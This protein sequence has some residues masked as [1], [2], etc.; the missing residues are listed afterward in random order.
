ML[1]HRKG[2]LLDGIG[3]EL[4]RSSAGG[5]RKTLS[6][7]LGAAGDMTVTATGGSTARTLAARFGERFN[8]RDFGAAGDGTTDDTTAF[9]AAITAALASSSIKTV[10][11]PDGRYSLPGAT[12]LDPG[13]GGIAIVG[14]SREGTI[15]LIN[16][17]TSGAKR[18][19]FKNIADTAKGDLSFEN[20]QFQ[21]TLAT[22]A[23][24]AGNPLWLDYYSHVRIHNCKFYSI[25]GEAMDFHYCGA[26]ECTDSWFENIA[27]DGVRVR[28]TSDCI[29]TDNTFYRLGDDPIAIHT[30]ASTL[31]SFTPQ[32][33]RI[34]VTNNIATNV[35][36]SIK[37]IGAKKLLC[38]LNVV[39][40]A[41][42][43]GIIVNYS[44][45]EGKN[46]TY[47]ILIADNIVSDMREVTS[48]TPGVATA[49]ITIKAMQAVGAS[50]TH[51]AF[52]YRWD[53][54]DGAV[55]RPWD[56]NQA[57]GTDSADA[58]P[59]MAGLVIRG[60]ICR[61]TLPTAAAFSDW[62]YGSAL[63]QGVA[64]DPAMDDADQRVSN[65]V[66][67]STVP[68][69]VNVIVE[70]NII[71]HVASTFVFPAPVTELDYYNISI[72]NNTVFDARDYGVTVGSA[73]KHFNC[74]IEGNVFDLDYFRENSN[75]N[76]DGSYDASTVPRAIDLGNCEGVQIKNNTFRNCCQLV[77]SNVMTTLLIEGNVAYC[78]APAAAGFNT[79]NKG[80]GHILL[81]LKAWR[82]IIADSDPTSATYG[83]IASQ[84]LTSSASMPSAGWYY[85]G[86]FVWDSGPATNGGGR[87]GWARV[88]TGTGHV[89]DTDWVEIGGVKG[90][91][92]ATDN[93]VTRWDAVTGRLLQNSTV[94]LSDA[95]QFAGQIRERYV[96]A[97]S[98]VQVSNTGNTSETA[99]ATI[100]IPAAAMGANGFVRVTFVFSHTN[101]GNNKTI[102]VRFGGLSGT[103]YLSTVNT[104]TTTGRAEVEIFNRNS[105]SSQVGFLTASAGFSLGLAAGIVTSAVDTASAVDLVISGQLASSGETVSLESYVVEVV[106]QA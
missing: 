93:A 36:G 7:W 86:W 85:A 70:N 37:I 92:S 13:A 19:T 68:S 60:N 48:A 26:F 40:L 25:G 102:R 5:R 103:V 88:T 4:V 61:R 39:T 45:S 33:E 74:I 46:A 52:P 59:P 80:I 81:G 66:Y 87:L 65:G 9:Q 49:Y 2:V 8:V 98:G 90:P 16:E 28:D 79:G 78:S 57:D 50:A 23:Q 97:A 54:T 94:T 38:A 69:F 58:M 84:M 53:S 67:F 75:S 105:A 3:A 27:A 104:T 6:A 83:E 89:L 73:A 29:V 63:S 51:S 17:G 95:G 82:Y 91:A 30:N 21:G 55:I 12:S 18:Y 35:S 41:S 96:V 106:K 1:S 47:D 11:V 77:A 71:E 43:H 72:R 56:W 76:T 62:G 64:Y 44:S 42:G 100:A 31:A 34:V 32:R 99:L 14:Q 22:T 101:S 15:L 20:V 24:R 10:F